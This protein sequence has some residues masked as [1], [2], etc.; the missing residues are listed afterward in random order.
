MHRFRRLRSLL[1]L[2]LASAV[3]WI[4]L[5]ALIST[6]DALLHGRRV[7]IGR[8]FEAAPL[9][10][11]IGAFCGFVFGLALSAAER[12]RSFD[13]LTLGRFVALG[14]ASALV[15]PVAANV[16]NIG[17]LSVAGVAYSIALFGIPGGVTAAALLSIARRAPELDSVVIPIAVQGSRQGGA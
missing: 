11:A 5:G 16:F 8:L 3:A 14:V 12:K 17:G 9:Y 10:A 15:I 1:G 7:V 2:A 6:A 4:P 13:S